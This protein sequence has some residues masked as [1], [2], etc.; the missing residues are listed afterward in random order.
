MNRIL[1][2]IKLLKDQFLKITMAGEKYARHVGVEVGENCRILT[3]TFG[4]EPWLIK[5]GNKVT[6]TS[7]V[8]IV[9]HDGSTWLFED[10]KGRRE[11]FR[12]VEIGNNVFIGFNSIILP[13]VKIEDNV[14]IAAGSVVTKSVPK[15]S[16]IGGNPARIIGS[17][18]SYKNKVLST[19]ISREE[20]DFSEPYRDRVLKALTKDFKPFMVKNDS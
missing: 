18:E 13:G 9:T 5:I 17:Y 14:V 7:G 10:E 16:I 11:L 3:T 6:I 1:Y 8:R 20:M 2:L 19:Y 15:G 4:S 12:R